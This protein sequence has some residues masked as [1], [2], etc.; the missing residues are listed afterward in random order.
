MQCNE[1][2]CARWIPRLSQR[3][4]AVVGGAFLFGASFPGAVASGDATRKLSSEGVPQDAG[5]G[6][7]AA[8]LGD[9]RA[10][11]EV[12]FQ[13]G[14]FGR[15]AE[16]ARE[17]LG[18]LEAEAP[19][20]GRKPADWRGLAMTRQLLA[21]A[22]EETGDVAGSLPVY[23][24]SLE[25][26]KKAAP[27]EAGDED[28]GAFAHSLGLSLQA[29]GKWEEAVGSFQQ[30]R[31]W[32][33]GGRHE[34]DTL[35]ALADLHL[36]RGNLALSQDLLAQADGA[37]KEPP[38]VVHLQVSQ[39]CERALGDFR[40]ALSL[41]QELVRRLGGDR[42]GEAA[43]AD[44]VWPVAERHALAVALTE[45]AG[46]RSRLKQSA[47]AEE[48]FALAGK[49]LGNLPE[50]AVVR[51]GREACFTSWAAHLLESGA[52]GQAM[53]HY[54]QAVAEMGAGV[55]PE[56]E[57]TRLTTWQ[58]YAAAALAV[59]DL[60]VARQA[61]E[62]AVAAAGRLAVVHP[63]RSQLSVMQA[64]LAAAEGKGAVA[65]TLA[66]Q[67]SGEA[68]AWLEQVLH[69]GTDEQILQLRRTVDP[70]SPLLAYPPERVTPEW[71]GHLERMLEGSQGRVLQARLHRL[72]QVAGLSETER[73]ALGKAQAEV[74][75]VESLQG[76]AAGAA[77][78]ARRRLAVAM[79]KFGQLPAPP[80]EVIPQG[81]VLVRQVLFQKA[82]PGGGKLTFYGALV[83]RGSQAPLWVELGP[84]DRINGLILRLTGHFADVL[85][86]GKSNTRPD[87][88]LTELGKL[89][90]PPPLEA[91]LPAGARLL[92][93]TDGLLPFAPWALLTPQRGGPPLAERLGSLEFV[94]GQQAV[95]EPWAFAGLGLDV[96]P[97]QEAPGAELT[98]SAAESV[99]REPFNAG[100]VEALRLMPK[101]KGTSEE[102][103]GLQAILAEQSMVA[104]RL[105][106][107]EAD[108][109]AFGKE[110]RR[111]ILHFACHGFSHV[112]DV[113][114]ASDPWLLYRSGLCLGPV[115]AG[116]AS[117]APSGGDNVLFAAEIARLALPKC[118]LVV[119]SACQSGMG[120]A[121][122]GET[123]H[124]LLRSFL[125]AGAPRVLASV[126]PV[127]DDQAPLFVQA[128]YRRLVA[129][130]RPPAEALWLTQRQW[131]QNEKIA[132]A[133]RM[134][135]AGAWLLYSRGWEVVSP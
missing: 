46:I 118:P 8:G 64:E 59:R 50:D 115:P 20:A 36:R 16:L 129:D 54:A 128:F 75:G 79:Q 132:P 101:L 74:V 30:A 25:D 5:P 112:S 52:A 40:S 1:T 114:P 104:P 26:L 44:S 7:G 4:W 117:A 56:L 98:G 92:L 102:A 96:F 39:R 78:E 38:S 67:A 81:A 10:E 65:A 15:A 103:A 133:R 121:Q 100:L 123:F 125:S 62:K 53:R 108:L 95:Q 105:R 6:V 109:L 70:V 97:V 126:Q 89:L 19:V 110:S 66:V 55:G 99:D 84:A 130:K 33:K 24:L 113:D 77:V 9:I 32:R 127:D 87:S 29:N 107:G 76:S 23:A 80:R 57:E 31:A 90:V 71:L 119:L 60:P 73:A 82:A 93:I 49:I 21:M 34:A 37:R 69:Q 27:A 41:A 135:T 85:R 61:V 13:G 14:D 11:C 111:S 3:F 45:L 68:L 124:G 47:E 18:R 94:T 51:A 63:L 35:V 43:A 72:G 2:K 120:Q 48:A 116:L 86:Q 28:L 91:V 83:Q 58:G 88:A 131:L 12:A 42:A 134:A 22:L 17:I 122:A 106:S